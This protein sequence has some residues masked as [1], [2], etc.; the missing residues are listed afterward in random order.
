MLKDL[1]DAE[2]TRPDDVGR[3][4][5]AARIAIDVLPHQKDPARLFQM[6]LLLKQ[7][8]GQDFGY[9]PF[10]TKQENEIALQAWQNWAKLQN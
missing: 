2:R 8:T 1:M 6:I 4:D 10:G 7:W 9:Q 3:V 5:L